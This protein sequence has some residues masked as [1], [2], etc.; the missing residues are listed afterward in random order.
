MHQKIRCQ[1]VS[2]DEVFK[3]TYQLALQIRKSG[4][5]PS[6]IIAI[7]RGGYVPARLLCDYLDVYQLSSIRVEHYTAGAQKS[8]QARLTMA[9]G[10]DLRDHKVLLVD[11]VDDTGDT[12]E[13]ACEH[14]TSLN[15]VQLK[16]AVLHHKISSPRVP[17]YCASTQHEWRW[18]TYPWAMVEDVKGFIARLDPPALSLQEIHRRLAEEFELELS[19][20]TL[21]DIYRLN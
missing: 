19:V 2:W 4:Y 15:P 5:Q 9:L 14:L 13:L 16:V 17:D 10:E 11:D 7:A 21:E 12:I 8:E 6:L 3:L 20:A 1:Q 18:I